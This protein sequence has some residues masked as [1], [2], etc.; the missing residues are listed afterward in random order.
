MCILSFNIPHQRHSGKDV[1]ILRQRHELYAVSRRRHPAQ[2]SGDT[3]N[4]GH[5]REVWL[6]LNDG[7]RRLR[8]F[9]SFKRHVA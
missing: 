4:W 7:Q 1:G 9:N 3:R 2:W 6:N 8:K 5:I